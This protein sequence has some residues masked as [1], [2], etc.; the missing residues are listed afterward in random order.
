MAIIEVETISGGYHSEP[1]IK[2]VSFSVEKGTFF[3]ILGPNGSGKTTLLK[4]I[5]GVLP[6]QAGHL[7]VKNKP[8]H[9]YSAKELAKVIAV[10]SQHSS[11]AFSY[12]VKETVSLGRYAH[13]R[14]FFQFWSD[15]DEAICQEVMRWTGVDRFQHDSIEFL[16]G[17]EK[18]RVFLAQALAQQPEILLLDEPTNHLDLSYQKELLDL[19]KNWTKEKGLTVISIFH[20][21]NL[22]GLYCDNILLLENGKV[23]QNASPKEVLKEKTIQQVYKTKIEMHQHPKVPAP[24]MVLL[25]SETQTDGLNEITEKN[26]RI[27]DELIV[28]H[29]PRMLRTMSSGVLGSGLGWHDTFI[30]RH[31]DKNYDC[32]NYREDM[33]RFVKEKGFNPLNTVGMMTA[34]KLRDAVY[35]CY[36]MDA[37]SLFI[38]VTAGV[39]NAVDVSKS[40]Q[41]DSN[42]KPGTIN[43]WVFINGKL[44][45]EAFIQS[46]MTAT[47]AKVKA[48]SELQIVDKETDTMATGT[49]TD[50]LLIAATQKGKFHEF[51]GTITPLGKLIGTGV[52]ECT[53]EAIKNGIKR[54]INE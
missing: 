44:S 43:I 32:R 39:G 14:D 6:L 20:D 3:G 51:A 11:Q 4:M 41:H 36:E 7:S 47:E 49:S 19:L 21:I 26:L 13:Q 9:A 16:S 54:R 34:V 42:L 30:N 17:G 27:H 22:A 29:S 53:I 10:L 40:I 52:Y 2:D 31:V 18:Q 45:E 33:T 24:L 37:F 48:L 25:P 15:K 38:V 35:K 5:S 50:S 12:T 23:I 46:I 1:V 8:I 28:L